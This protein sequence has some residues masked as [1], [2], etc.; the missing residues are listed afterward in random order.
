MSEP[1]VKAEIHPV[2]TVLGPTRLAA[3]G[4]VDAHAHVWVDAVEGG[5]PDAPRL[6]DEPAIRAELWSF[7]SSGGQA[8]ID[9]Q[10]PGAGRNAAR[11][12]DLAE[13]SGVAIVACTGFH[14]SRYYAAGHSPWDLDGDV[15][16]PR[17]VDELRLGMVDGGE[18]LGC[19]AG[20]IKA[21][22][23]GTLGGGADR[24]FTAAVSAARDQGVMLVVHTER[25]LGVEELAEFLL[26]LNMSSQDVMLC[27]VDKRPDLGLHRELARAGFLLEYDTFLRPKY[28]PSEH[29]W[30]LIDAML[31]AGHAESL[32]CGLDLAD[33][34]LWRFGGDPHGMNGLSQ[35]VVPQL[36][37]RGVDAE[38]VRRLTGGNVRA[39]LQT[40]GLRSAT[41]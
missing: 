38:R 2:M 13:S 7:A 18:P 4:L 40:S 27:H 41:A 12:A 14:L 37:A 11:L 25:G 32:A 3:E 16:C 39:R 17:F 19:R 6:D 1:A 34:C 29:L 22:H 10:P 23:P 9:C 21:A 30:P 35:V 24:M 33:R 8:L 31:A 20:A 15:L 26:G 36:R 28:A 5:A